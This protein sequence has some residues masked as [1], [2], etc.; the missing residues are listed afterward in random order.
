MTQLESICY[1]YGVTVNQ[2]REKKKTSNIVTIRQLICFEL[3]NSKISFPKIGKLVNRSH[4]TVIHSVNKV[5]DYLDVKDE[6]ILKILN[7]GK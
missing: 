7:H 6:L 1:D 2:V 5:N 3:R 4:A